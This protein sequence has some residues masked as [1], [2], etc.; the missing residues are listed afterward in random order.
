MKALLRLYYVC[1]RVDTTLGALH[2]AFQLYSRQR[3]AEYGLFV[4]QVPPKGMGHQVRSVWWF[5]LDTAVA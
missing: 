2:L 4:A 5:S 3:H 1:A